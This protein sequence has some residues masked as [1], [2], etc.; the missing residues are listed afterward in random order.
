MTNNYLKLKKYINDEKLQNKKLALEDFEHRIMYLFGITN[1][2]TLR[3]NMQNFQDTHIID[4]K[5]DDKGSWW[6]IIK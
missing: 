6:V 5:K 1:M 3:T 4:I 2:K